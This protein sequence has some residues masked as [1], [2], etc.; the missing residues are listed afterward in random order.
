MSLIKSKKGA[1][2]PVMTEAVFADVRSLR[3][4]VTSRVIAVVVVALG[5]PHVASFPC[6]SGDVH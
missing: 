5:S 1:Q 2:L 3:S 6:K 4:E